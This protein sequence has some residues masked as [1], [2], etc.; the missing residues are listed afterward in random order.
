MRD[1]KQITVYLDADEQVKFLRIKQHRF[2][3]TDTDAIR[4]LIEVENQKILSE[5]IS[6]K[7]NKNKDE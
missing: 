3:K 1:K 6:I 7:I 2:R 4:Y 5:N